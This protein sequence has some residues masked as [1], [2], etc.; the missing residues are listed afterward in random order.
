V[1]RL[2]V[3]HADVNALEKQR[4]ATDDDENADCQ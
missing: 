1:V 3:P 2:M 4:G